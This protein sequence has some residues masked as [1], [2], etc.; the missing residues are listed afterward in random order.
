M[1]MSFPLGYKG[2]VVSN[3]F[4][5]FWVVFWGELAL[6]LLG[7]VVLGELLREGGLVVPTPPDNGGGVLAR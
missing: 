4:L 3:E 5:L 6:S 1:S 2:S 7:L